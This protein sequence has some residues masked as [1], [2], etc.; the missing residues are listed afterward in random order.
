MKTIKLKKQYK[1]KVSDIYAD[2]Y[3]QQNQKSRELFYKILGKNLKGKKL[4]DLACGDGLDLVYYDKLGADTFGIDMSK[5]FVSAAKKNNPKL[6]NQ[7]TIDDFENLKLPKNKFNIV[8]SKYAIQTS[9]RIDKVFNEAHRILKP[10]GEFYLLVTHPIRQYVE[11]RGKNK[12]YFIP[13]VVNSILFDGALTV[14][15]PAHT[16][17]EYL[18]PEILSKFDLQLFDE[19]YDSAAEQIDGDVYPGFMVMKFKKR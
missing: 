11:R 16:F 9:S 8:V 12:N 17:L 4:V 13:K 15:E 10:K 18:S 6:A 3:Y 14:R 7:I 1:N 2:V 19:K 5:D